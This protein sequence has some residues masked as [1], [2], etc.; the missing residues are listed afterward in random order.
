MDI[1]NKP[2]KTH[3]NHTLS[4]DSC[5]LSLGISINISVVHLVDFCLSELFSLSSFSSW[6]RFGNIHF[7]IFSH[8]CSWCYWFWLS[9]V[10]K[11][12]LWSHTFNYASIYFKKI[13][14]SILCL[15]SLDIINILFEKVVLFLFILWNVWIVLHKIIFHL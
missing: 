9:H 7:I 4:P 14:L 15:Y 11:F 6:Y 10:P 13:F 5:P 1:K 8:S 2:S 12:L 3:A